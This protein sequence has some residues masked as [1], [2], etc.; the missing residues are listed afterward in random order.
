VFIEADTCIL[1]QYHFDELKRK[2]GNTF[3]E[4]LKQVFEVS[5]LEPRHLADR[6]KKRKRC[7]RFKKLFF[8]IFHVGLLKTNTITSFALVINSIGLIPLKGLY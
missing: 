8:S 5:Y 2:Q 3:E 4:T 6:T 1:M 7:N